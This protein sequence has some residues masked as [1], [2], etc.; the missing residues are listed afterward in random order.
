MEPSQDANDLN[1]KDGE[2]EKLVFYRIFCSN[3]IEKF[4]E[5]AHSSYVDV[6]LKECEHILHSMEDIENFIVQME[7]S[8]F[9][10][11]KLSLSFF[12]MLLH[13]RI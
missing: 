7:A 9:R 5:R 6:S 2:G 8:M 13:L 4:L 3:F 11:F 12:I 10:S 1:G